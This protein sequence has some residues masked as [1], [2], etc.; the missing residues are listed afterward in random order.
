MK[1][2]KKIFY[3]FVALL[4]L[5]IV[6][7]LLSA[8][9]PNLSKNLGDFL[10]PG[11]KNE[12]TQN[13]ENA[14]SDNGLDTGITEGIVITIP[15][16][17]Q[18]IL[19]NESEIVQPENVAGKTGYEPVKEDTEEIKE[20]EGETLAKTLTNGETGEGLEFDP[21]FY[22]YYAMLDS[23]LQSIYRQVYANT[24]ALND[25]FTPVEK[26]SPN[27]F[28]SAFMAVIGD[29]PELFWMDTAYGCKYLPTGQCAAIYLQFNSTATNLEE[30]KQKFETSADTIVQGAINLSTDYDKE[31]Y[32]HD[33]L[34]SQIEY[35]LSAPLNQSAY[36]ALIGGQTVCAGYARAYQYIMQ[37]LGI[38]C[39]Y[40]TGFAGENHAWNIIS[41]DD[42]FYNVDTT[43]DDTDP[44]TYD[45][46]NKSDG[47]FATNHM[48][49]EL[50]VYL[51]ACNGEK[52]KNLESVESTAGDLASTDTNTTESATQESAISEP[53]TSESAA[54][55]PALPDPASVETQ[56]DN[57]RTLQ[58]V[59]VTKEDVLTNIDEYY[60]D[61]YE[62]V[63]QNGIGTYQFQNVISLENV[64]FQ[65]YEDYLNDTY[66]DGYLNNAQAELDAAN[67]I[68]DIRI[69]EL[70]GGYLLLTHN[71]VME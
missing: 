64:Y 43:W 14:L 4:A 31:I 45:Y 39:Y 57:G 55:E 50:S 32:V 46:F 20:S 6:F 40:C 70:Q 34:I 36:S 35:N 65:M 30:N 12:N 13:S 42:G 23:T 38:P 29:H 60:E 44:N 7:I 41:L 33:T 62:N 25:A 56:T 8:I 61:C 51:P 58:D 1:I 24:L 68:Y 69:E 48:R 17:S 67:F 26:I 63:I 71:M 49:K 47:D 15:K 28:R 52:Y 18:Y 9:Q 66:N 10:F 21:E 22:P 59:G 5:L 53:I 37:E 3:V 27:Q 54:E 11:N 2:L 19:P 16:E